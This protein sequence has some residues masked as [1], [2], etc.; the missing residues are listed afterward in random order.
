MELK[1]VKELEIES[2][3]LPFV[4][5]CVIRNC[6]LNVI[7]PP[8]NHLW[9]FFGRV[10]RVSGRLDRVNR[11]WGI[12]I[13]PGNRI[14]YGLGFGLNQTDIFSYPSPEPNNII[15]NRVTRIIH[16]KPE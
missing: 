3:S 15:I 14:E 4:F 13:I 6:N 16:P 11:F 1:S 9:L 2:N 7:P 12:K 8:H 10:V 5:G